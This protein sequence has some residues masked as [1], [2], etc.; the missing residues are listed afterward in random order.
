MRTLMLV[1]IV[2]GLVSAAMVLVGC[3][4]VRGVG[5]DIQYASDQTAE[6]LRGDDDDEADDD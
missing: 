4:T 5:E 6:A 2:A 3:S 1:M